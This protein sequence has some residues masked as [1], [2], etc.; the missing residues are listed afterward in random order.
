MILA[1]DLAHRGVGDEGT[2]F[3]LMAGWGSFAHATRA[4][5][6]WRAGAISLLLAVASVGTM[7]GCGNVSVTDRTPPNPPQQQRPPITQETHDL[8][9]AAVD[10]DPALNS[11]HVVTSRPYYLLAAV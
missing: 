5:R 9:I 8:A 11:Q 7:S 10:F 6:S 1:L 4:T 3:G 2:M